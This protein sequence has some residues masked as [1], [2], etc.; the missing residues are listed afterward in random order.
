MSWEL[1][2]GQTVTFGTAEISKCV[3]DQ[4]TL[5]IWCKLL[6]PAQRQP[7][8]L[9][10]GADG[11]VWVAIGKEGLGLGPVELDASA[12]M[13]PLATSWHLL[14]L[15]GTS[16]GA[17][18]STTLALA[19]AGDARPTALCSAPWAPA[20]LLRVGDAAADLGHVA[21]VQ[22]WCRRLSLSEL[23]A[24]WL[25]G[26][27]RHGLPAPAEWVDWRAAPA[28]GR[29]RVS[30][31]AADAASGAAL[32]GV[33]VSCAA[34]EAESGEDGAFGVELPG[35]AAADGTLVL[36][37]R[38]A[39]YAP[40][41]LRVA[42][43]E[44]RTSVVPVARMLRLGARATLRGAEGGTLVDEASGTTFSVP[45][46][47]FLNPDGTA[48]VGTA[49]VAAAAIDPSDASALAAMPGDFSATTVGGEAVMLRSFGA[50]F[51]SA[52][53]AATGDELQIDAA[54]EGVGI[55]WASTVEMD[56][57]DKCAELPSAWL[58]DTPSGKWVQAAEPLQVDGTLLPAPGTD[59]FGAALRRGGGAAREEDASGAAAGAV[60]SKGKKGKM[61]PTT[62]E[63]KAAA[64]A[65]QEA[66]VDRFLAF[67][68]KPKGVRLRMALR[69]NAAWINCDAP[70]LACLLRGRLRGWAARPASWQSVRA[71]ATGALYASRS[72]A[73]IG[74]GGDFAMMVQQHS[75]VY[76]E[77][78]AD[79]EDVREREKEAAAAAAA[80]RLWTQRAPADCA[81]RMVRLGPFVALGVGEIK[82]LGELRL[83]E[84]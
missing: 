44:G 46:A 32:C 2:G 48:F 19:G 5:A 13:P 16:R 57:Q 6:P 9:I 62:V 79:P 45:K 1:A 30:G 54:S 61:G 24:L 55:E 84:E 77:V 12:P 15:G 41:T 73:A 27:A 70:Y 59:D 14:I 47:A 71:V 83:E 67:F 75:E 26:C 17:A 58:F 52:T 80:E 65:R 64:A 4:F 60:K 78:E 8:T 28:C 22:L 7:G 56:L 23:R 72:Y 10:A 35:E 31:A 29:V 36:S 43:Q 34:A 3:E 66:T 49:A 40:Q 20:A 68:S 42:V 81:E 63:D 25:E 21:S 50:F 39:G 74:A 76:V 53:D 18:S 37:L 69:T 11:S 51:F 82:E 38:V 33:H